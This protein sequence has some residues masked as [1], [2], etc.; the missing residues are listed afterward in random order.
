MNVDM[1]RLLVE[2]YERDRGVSSTDN[3]TASAPGE[4]SSADV[5]AFQQAMKELET[6]KVSPLLSSKGAS[7]GA[8]DQPG[9]ALSRLDQAVTEGDDEL[10]RDMRASLRNSSGS[11]DVG[12]MMAMNQLVLR[13]AF[14]ANMAAHVA[15]KSMQAVDRLVNMN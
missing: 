12:Q 3:A 11:Q 1:T 4:A 8:G 5:Q 2:R 9:S 14:D 13:K 6:A 10:M 15:G 7:S